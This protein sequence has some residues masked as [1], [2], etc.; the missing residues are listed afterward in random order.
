MDPL[1]ITAVTSL[2][3]AA[4]SAIQAVGLGNI[5]VASAL[6]WMFWVMRKG[7]GVIGPF[8]VD[9]LV[10]TGKLADKGI[11][12]R[13]SVKLVDDQGGCVVP[14]EWT[15]TPSKGLR[16]VQG[17]FPAQ[18]TA[19]VALNLSPPATDPTWSREAL[20]EAMLPAK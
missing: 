9:A 12:V 13:L 18:S 3:A 4:A 5:I 6:V 19:Q 14:T 11:D 20:Q 10:T 1:T 7:A 2:I 16:E 8:F 15:R 17:R